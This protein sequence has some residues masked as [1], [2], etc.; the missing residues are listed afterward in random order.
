MQHAVR[1]RTHVVLVDQ[2]DDPN[3]WATPVP[4]N[5]IE[6]TAVPPTGAEA[7][8]N[9]SDWLRLVFTHEYAHVLHLDR[10][11]GWAALARGVFGR[12][13]F[14]FPNLTLPLWHI[15]GLATFAESRGA[16]GRLAAGDFHAI[17]G[18]GSPRR[19]IRAARPR[20]RRAR[21]LAGGQRL[22]CLRRVLPRLSG[23]AVWR[24]EAGRALTPHGRPSAVSWCDRI[25]DGLRHFTWQLVARL[26]AGAGGTGARTGR[27][28]SR[29]APDP[30][31]IPGLR[32]PVRLRREHRLLQARRT[33]VSVARP[34][35]A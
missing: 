34:D 28:R 7:T 5:L 20:E 29:G 8:G 18:R 9:T 33:W 35:F 25:Q 2:A 24:R 11:R 23:A 16:E 27:R 22:V 12:A 10:S 3:G 32:T 19:R 15:E 1:G 14:V 17:V 31:R 4:Y 13:P 30:S 26:L 6:I 21:R